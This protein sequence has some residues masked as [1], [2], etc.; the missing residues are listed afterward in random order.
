MSLLHS[1]YLTVLRDRH[2]TSKDFREAADNLNY[3]L[4]HKVSDHLSTEQQDVESPLKKTAGYFF[5][6]KIVLVP[7]LRS[8]LAMLNVFWR[9]FSEAKVGV[10]GFERN[11][12]TKQV[13]MYYN[14]LPSLEPNTRVM[15]LD[16][17]L[18]TGGTAVLAARALVEHGYPKAS[19]LFAGVIGCPD[20][21]AALETAFPGIKIILAAEDPEL[22]DDKFIVPGLG[23]FGDRYFGT[24]D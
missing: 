21:R 1:P 23:D 7:I 13:A 5:K 17:M 22:N 15:I 19:L 24:A 10:L 2:T 12:E 4:A 6:E 3:L 20:G 11:E 8:G 9:T 16:P 18:A 14:K